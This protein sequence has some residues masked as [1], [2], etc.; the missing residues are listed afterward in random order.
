MSKVIDAIK[1]GVLPPD[2]I[3]RLSVVEI[4]TSDTYD[5]DG[6]SI[7]GGLMDQRLGTLEPRQRC[8]TCGNIS[9][10]CPGHYGHIELAVPVIHVEFAKH[11]YKLLSTTCRGCGRIL[12]SPEQR[13]EFKEIRSEEI[14]LFGKVN[15]DTFMD[16]VKSAKKYKKFKECPVCGMAQS[17]VKFAKPTSFF[18]IE[19]EEFNTDDESLMEEISR[20]LTANMIR[21]WFERIID[22]DLELLDFEAN[23]FA[24]PT[25]DEEGASAQG[26]M[27]ITLRYDWSRKR[28]DYRLDHLLLTPIEI[29]Q[30][31]GQFLF[32]IDAPSP[33]EWTTCPRED[34]E[35]IEELL[36]STSFLLARFGDLEWRV[37]VREEGMSH[38]PDLLTQL[39]P[40]EILLYWSLLTP[41]QLEHW[42]RRFDRMHKRWFRGPMFGKGPLHGGPH[43]PFGRGRHPEPPGP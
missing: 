10:N 11:I 16:V 7:A 5:E 8:R 38:R 41:E 19:Q 33:D 15:D 39:T 3:R 43:H 21:E 42:N 35:K 30:P 14:R 20:R 26:A 27:N 24:E 9:I 36:K 13:E 18:E 22:E 37:L 25:P 40:E 32:Y 2:E 23:S 29:L 4:V 31:S 1:F 34:A 12:L 28:L 6:G 17:N